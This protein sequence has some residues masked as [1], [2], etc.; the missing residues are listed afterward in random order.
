MLRIWR[1]LCYCWCSARR[2]PN[3]SSWIAPCLPAPFS[4]ACSVILRCCARNPVRYPQQDGW[5]GQHKACKV[6]MHFNHAFT[7][8]RAPLSA[9]MQ[10][11]RSAGRKRSGWVVESAGG[12][13]GNCQALFRL[14]ATGSGAHSTF[15]ASVPQEE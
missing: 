15:L 5:N 4:I 13:S 10:L 11:F 6:R 7:R 3:V 8:V 12:I 1:V 14:S 9:S 2:R